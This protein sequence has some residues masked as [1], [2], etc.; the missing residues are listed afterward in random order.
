[1]TPGRSRTQASISDHGRDLAARQHVVADRDLFEL[2]RLDH[3]LVDALE[4]AAHDDRRPARARASATR[5]CV[6]GAP[7]GVISRRG[8][9]SSGADAASMRAR[10]HV[11]LHHHAGAAAGR[12]VV[13]GAVP[14][15]GVLADVAASSDQMPAG[16]RL[17]G[18]AHAERPG[19]HL[20]KEREDGRAPHDSGLSPLVA[21]A[22]LPQRASI[23][24]SVPA[25]DV[26]C[27][28]RGV[29]ERQQHGRRRC[30][31]FDLD[32]VAGAEIMHRVDRAELVA[33]R[34]S[35]AA[36]PTRSAW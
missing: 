31:G 24:R 22:T 13:D 14:V 29:G 33:V 25:G 35:T 18:E 26:D 5:A 15:G 11:G 28:H 32:E 27:R 21:A 23:D 3:A 34:A 9:V 36:R 2:P 1:M 17:A 19:K 8:R 30:A 4:P 12:R 10:Q 20:G 7:R 16:Q 6:S